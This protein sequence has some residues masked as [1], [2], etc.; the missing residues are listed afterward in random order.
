MTT[1][2]TTTDVVHVRL[3]LIAG[4]DRAGD[5]AAPAPDLLDELDQV[6]ELIREV[7][8][9]RDAIKAELVRRIDGKGKRKAELDGCI[10]ETNPPTEDHYHADAVRRELEPLIEA[11]EVDKETLDALIVQPPRPPAPD[12]KVD[13]RVVNTLKSS[14]NR[15][16]LAALQRARTRTD[17]RRS[18][19]VLGRPVEATAEED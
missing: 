10:L 1:D 14:D 2:N 7:N 18:L 6:D 16:L 15:A 8:G 3:G 9:Y 13:K 4:D 12:E 19:K 11:G 17:N 5:L